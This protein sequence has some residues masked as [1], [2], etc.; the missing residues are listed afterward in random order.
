MRDY[1]GRGGSVVGAAYVNVTT[2]TA[3]LGA[4]AFWSPRAFQ[5]LLISKQATGD[6]AV[7]AQLP[8]KC[9]GTPQVYRLDKDHTQPAAPEPLLLGGT[10][11]VTLPP[12]AAALVVCHM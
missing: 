9:H 3:L 4:H 10:P 6:M 12:I 11:S 8:R 7:T 2:D 5:L 1:D